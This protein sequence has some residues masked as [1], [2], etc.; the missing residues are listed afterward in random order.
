MEN[1]KAS[2]ASLPPS[3]FA[4]L[5]PEFCKAADGMLNGHGTEAMFL[6]DVAGSTIAGE[7]MQS[8]KPIAD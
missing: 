7:P 3:I 6:H 1:T 4:I 2:L 5:Y 8:A